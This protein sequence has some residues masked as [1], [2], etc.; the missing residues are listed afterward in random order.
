MMLHGL[1]LRLQLL[2]ILL[3]ACGFPEHEPRLSP[4][5]R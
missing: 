1:Q 4:L 3:K 5:A 2:A